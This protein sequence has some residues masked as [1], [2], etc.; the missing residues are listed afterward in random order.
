ME[1]I[2]FHQKVSRMIS[3]KLSINQLAEFSRSSDKGKLRIVNQQIIPN[4]FLIPWYQTTKAKIKKF[5]EEKGDTQPIL[6]GINQLMNK[7]PENKRQFIN[8]N[9][10][11]EALQKFID[12]KLPEILNGIDYEIV[13]PRIKSVFISGLDVIVAPEVVVKGIINGRTVYGGVKIH[14]S[15]SKPFTIKESRCVAACVYK[16][17]TDVVADENETVLPEMCFSLDVFGN[18]LVS[19]KDN[20]EETMTDIRNIC[21]EVLEIWPAA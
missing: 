16:Y 7:K 14:I 15:K 17:I 19:A 18:R 9:V 10:S 8:K 12:F 4:K 6:D 13:K 1:T 20:Y 21:Q 3:A 2:L 11:I 5:F